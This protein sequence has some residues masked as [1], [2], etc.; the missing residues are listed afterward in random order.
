MR[1]I[2]RKVKHIIFKLLQPYGFSVDGVKPAGYLSKEDRSYREK[3]FKNLRSYF[4]NKWGS[5][6]Q[7]RCDS[8]VDKFFAG[9]LSGK[10][11]VLEIG[12]GV[13]FV[14]KSIL[15]R[16]PSLIF[17]SFE[18]DGYLA[19]Y[20][21]EDFKEYNF[22]SISC[23]GKDLSGA[24]DDSTDVAI[25]FGVFT[26]LNFSNIVK[27]IDEVERVTKKGSYFFFDIFDTDSNSSSMVS[28]FEYHSENGDNRPYISGKLLEKLLLKKG[29]KML[30][31]FQESI[32]EEYFSNKFLYE[33]VV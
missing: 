5:T 15:E 23:N 6:V 18:L 20:L 12:A 32:D 8:Y 24:S 21:E 27:Y 1:T 9:R 30:E 22:S 33:K 29:F 31:S 14:T 2:K 28:A 19:R 10:E 3:G 11:T 4:E 26:Y 25:A 7:E 13:G 16:F 17:Y